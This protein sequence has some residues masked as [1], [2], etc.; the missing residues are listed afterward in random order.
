MNL[1]FLKSDILIKVDPQTGLKSEKMGNLGKPHFVSP[2][3]DFKNS[4]FFEK[5]SNRAAPKLQNE[6]FYF[7][8]NVAFFRPACNEAYFFS[9][10]TLPRIVHLT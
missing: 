7:F 10:Q 6:E 1:L 3:M 5:I 4:T 2:H 8:L 9:D